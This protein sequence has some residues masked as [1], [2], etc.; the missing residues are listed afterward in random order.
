MFSKTRVAVL[1][2]GPSS[3]YEVS[4]KTGASILS[5]IP[6]SHHPIDIFIDKSGHWH[7]HGRREAPE[8]I[9]NKID[10]VWNALHGEYGEDGSIQH[11]L[12]MHHIPFIG[13]PR[14]PTL[15][16]MNK[17]LAKNMVA[18][19]GIQ[20]P[21]FKFYRKEDIDDY[22]VLA[23]ELYRTFPQ[24]LVI[25]PVS[26]GSSLCVS[27]AE[28]L[29]GI[30]YAL[31]LAFQDSDAII[32][33]EYIPG[34]EAICGIIEGYRGDNLY[35]LLPVEVQLAP[36]SLFLDYYGKH[37]GNASFRAPGN[38]SA[39]LKR[40]L[41]QTAIKIHELLG[42]RHFSSTDFIVHPTRG[43]Y[44]LE[45]DSVP[46]LGEQSAFKAGLTSVGGSMEH[47]VEHMLTLA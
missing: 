11:L 17:A 1:R 14:Y 7:L 28:T 41:Q 2:G 10:V 30:T 15:L 22:N 39:S 5:A 21:Y 26:K 43:V 31:E 37:S 34:T 42:L 19:E 33:E 45:T 29:E 23:D 6:E 47:F 16:A 44:F 20:T 24:P 38:F 46:V 25:K 4:I 40:E 35:T 3:E 36:E 8:R 27:V 13:S 32:V 9:L 12:E 18:N